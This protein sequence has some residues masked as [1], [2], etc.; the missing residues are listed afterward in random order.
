MIHSLFH[1]FLPSINAISRYLL[2][3]CLLPMITFAQP[4]KTMPDKTMDVS[5]TK[6]VKEYQQQ[7]WKTGKVHY[8][9]FEGG[10]YGIV[11]DQN[12][13]LLPM[14]L[15][16]AYRIEGTVLALKGEFMTDMLTTQ[17]WGK[18]F[19]ISDYKVLEVGVEANTH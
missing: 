11:T 10:F 6:T 8:L 4:D 9:N 17:Q 14:N 7:G 15:P 12:E 1:I 18:L 5:Q 19:K 3:L 13:K 2:S 16:K